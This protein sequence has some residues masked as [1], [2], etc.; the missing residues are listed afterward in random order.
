MKASTSSPAKETTATRRRRRQG[1]GGRTSQ[2]TGR[3]PMCSGE[4]Q[5]LGLNEAGSA[6]ALEGRSWKGIRAPKNHQSRQRSWP[7][8]AT[9]NGLFRIYFGGP[10]PSHSHG[11]RPRTYGSPNVATDHCGSYTW[12]AGRRVDDKNEHLFLNTSDSLDNMSST[13]PWLSIGPQRGQEREL[14]WKLIMKP[15]QSLT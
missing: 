8:S 7:T 10:L 15:K 14:H 12:T 9:L 2:W 6:E 1:C 3:R 13:S 4:G 11:R 5:R